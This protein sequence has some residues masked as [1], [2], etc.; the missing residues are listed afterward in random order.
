MASKGFRA[1]LPE[2][3]EIGQ[4]FLLRFDDPR[5]EAAAYQGR[6]QDMS[7]SGLLCFDAPDG[8]RPPKGT[9]VTVRSIHDRH[10][11][12]GNCTFSSEI[13][14]RGRL[15]GRLPVLLV[16]PPESVEDRGSRSAHRVSVCLRGSLSWRP[17]P[18]SPQERSSAVITNLSGGGAQL[19]TRHRVEAEFVEV[20]L[21]APTPFIEE[22]ARRSLPRAGIAP[23]RMSLSANPLS[24]ACDK[25]R[26]RFSGIRC[27]VVSV[28][29]H[30]RDERGPVFAL[31]LAFCEVQESCFQLVRF[32]ERQAAR[33]GL[34][35]TR[36][37][38]DRDE[39]PRTTGR[40]R[41]KA[42]AAA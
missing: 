27:Q 3:I 28:R 31:S 23:R 32:L 29:E 18:R 7:K 22:I 33:K 36:R 19:F 34:E 40:G 2:G 35:A 4:R 5:V 12:S 1:Q 26:E 21:D 30:R 20:Q 13:R 38:A 16:E 11:S 6:L 41:R 25:V 24:D 15:R 14:G 10:Q 17:H 42:L 39:G 8:V 9:P 37:E